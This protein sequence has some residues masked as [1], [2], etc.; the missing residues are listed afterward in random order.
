MAKTRKIANVTV[1]K[2]D[3]S[4]TLMSHVAGVRRGNASRDVTEEQGTLDEGDWSFARADRSTGI[5][6][7]KRNPVLP[8]MPNLP[9]P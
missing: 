7:E 1:G 9:P 6:P 8:S 3:V 5:N 2:A 4:P